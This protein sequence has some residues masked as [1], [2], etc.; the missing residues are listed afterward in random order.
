MPRDLTNFLLKLKKLDLKTVKIKLF[1][2]III[3]GELWCLNL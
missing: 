3:V 2:L 1:V